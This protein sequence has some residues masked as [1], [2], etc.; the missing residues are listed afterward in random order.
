MDAFEIHFWRF[1]GRPLGV[2]LEVRTHFLLDAFRW[3]QFNGCYHCRFTA[4]DY[5][6]IHE[7]HALSILICNVTR[8]QKV[9][10]GVAGS[11][12]ALL[13]IPTRKS[14][15]FFSLTY[16]SRLVRRGGACDSWNSRA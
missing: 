8:T 10:P 15:G 9:L 14:L 2:L 6:T 3:K 5:R 13:P 7:M 1:G 4:F 11:D 16:F 12:F